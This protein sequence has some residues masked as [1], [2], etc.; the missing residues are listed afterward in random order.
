LELEFTIRRLPGRAASQENPESGIHF[1]N[2]DEN[3]L[4]LGNRGL[5]GSEVKGKRESPTS[6]NSGRNGALVIVSA[7][8]QNRAVWVRRRC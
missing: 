4:F 7:S 6:A 1:S 3:E 5:P 2:Q 8:F